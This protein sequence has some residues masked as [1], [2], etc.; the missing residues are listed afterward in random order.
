MSAPQDYTTH[1]RWVPAYHFVLSLLVLAILVGSVVNVV[2]SAGTG[3]FY[4]ATLILAISIALLMAVYFTRSFALR[5]QDRVIRAEENFRH[6]LR[7]GKPL[8]PRLTVRQIIGLRFASDQEV[9]DLIAKAVADNMAEDDIKKAIKK[10]RS[11]DYR[12]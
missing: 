3:G 7:T 12:V 1:R 8:D 2:K 4:S 5:A 11:D 9:D 6:Y 10:W